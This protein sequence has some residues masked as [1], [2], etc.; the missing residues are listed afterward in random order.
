MEFKVKKITDN[1]L[2]IYK[3]YVNENYYLGYYRKYSEL[4]E[5]LDS[6]EGSE[7]FELGMNSKTYGGNDYFLYVDDWESELNFYSTENVIN[8]LNNDE[9]FIKYLIKID[10]FEKESA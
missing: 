3:K 10:Y 7:A 2:N 9:E 8:D 5:F 6:F 4:Y 1:L